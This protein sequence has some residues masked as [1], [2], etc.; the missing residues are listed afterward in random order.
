M[1]VTPFLLIINEKFIDPYF[2]VKVSD[3]DEKNAG[4]VG[5]NKIIIVGYGHFGSTVGR[6]LKINGFK[7]TILDHDS[8]RVTLLRSNGLKV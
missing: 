8:D 6:L 5:E 1:C 2:N 4:M 3:D 7:A